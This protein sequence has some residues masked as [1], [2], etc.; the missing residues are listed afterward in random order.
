MRREPAER[1]DQCM[2]GSRLRV[3]ENMPQW[4]KILTEVSNIQDEGVG[5][6]FAYNHRIVSSPHHGTAT[7]LEALDLRRQATSSRTGSLAP[8]GVLILLLYNS[9]VVLGLL[10][11]SHG[12]WQIQTMQVS[13]S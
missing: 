1:R 10:A 6:M 5:E 7:V 3:R 13:C 8:F 12:A 4:D 9:V 2:Q 11:V